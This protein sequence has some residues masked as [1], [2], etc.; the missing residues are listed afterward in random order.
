MPLVEQTTLLPFHIAIPITTVAG[1]IA[2]TT[3]TILA[4]NTHPSQIIHNVFN[5]NRLIE[6]HTKQTIVLTRRLA[7]EKEINALLRDLLKS[8]NVQLG[9]LIAGTE[10]LHTR[11]ALNDLQTQA[12]KAQLDAYH[13]RRQLYRLRQR[14]ETTK[15]ANLMPI[16]LELAI[17]TPRP[18]ETLEPQTTRNNQC[19][20]L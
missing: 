8:K 19:T 10:D 2:A 16:T 4:T 1:A 3:A 17:T 14:L 13:S 6:E 15:K 12:T 18:A 5:L 20:I 7:Q 11:T 9:A